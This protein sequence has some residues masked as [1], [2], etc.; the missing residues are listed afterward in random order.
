MTTAIQNRYE[1]VYLFDVTNGNPNG[2]PD[3]GNMPRLDP[4]S[5]KGLVTDVCLKR[6][7]RNFIEMT[8]VDAAGNP[9]LQYQIFVKDKSVLNQ[10]I[11]LAYESEAVKNALTAWDEYQKDKKNKK[12][13]SEEKIKQPE[14][15]YEDIAQQWMC[16]NFYD[17]RAFGAVMSTG[18]K[19]DTGDG[20]D[21]E[22]PSKI[23]KRAGQ[24]RGPVQFAFG[25]SVDPIIPLEISITRMAVTNEKDLLKERT[26]GRKHIV[27]Y[28][29]YRAHGFIS[30]NLAKKT[31]FS[32][33]DLDKLWRSLAMM[34]DHDRSAA[35]GEMAA[36]HLVVFKHATALG[37][38]PAHQLFDRVTVERV[39]GEG[40]SPAAQFSDYAVKVDGEVLKQY[41]K[42]VDVV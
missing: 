30:A 17:I 1:F 28:G 39:H 19:S 32:D 22:E 24:V 27:P 36:R 40:G 18:T 29:L 3:A 37:N 33:L 16:D 13:K 42:D 23:V 4:E 35:R 38:A 11:E 6:K 25:K 14:K 5:S 20:G 7:I 26:M 31:G 9:S 12:K 34:F 10:T 21:V 2:D 15:H 41:R 8:E